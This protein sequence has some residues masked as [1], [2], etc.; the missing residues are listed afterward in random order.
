MRSPDE[1]NGIDRISNAWK[2]LVGKEKKNYSRNYGR[3]YEN[4]K[5]DKDKYIENYAN[6]RNMN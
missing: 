6:W 5:I 2:L 4:S 3:I 1:K